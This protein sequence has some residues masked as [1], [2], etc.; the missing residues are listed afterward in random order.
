MEPGFRWNHGCDSLGSL[1]KTGC[2]NWATA[3]RMAFFAMIMFFKL[4][5]PLLPWIDLVTVT[6]LG[7]FPLETD[8]NG[9]KKGK[10]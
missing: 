2:Q 1:W 8:R 3:G 4:L 9:G 6:L 7:S 10:K 5:T